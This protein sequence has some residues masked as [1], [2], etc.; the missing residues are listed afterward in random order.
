M[1][2]ADCAEYGHFV[3]GE[4]A[5]GMAF[6]IQTFTAKITLAVSGAISM[7]LL[8]AVG[9]AEGEGAVQTQET[10]AWLWR[11][12]TVIPVI[13]G[14]ASFLILLLFYRL[15]D[16]DVSVMMKANSGEITREEALS[17]LSPKAL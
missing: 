17:Q 13:A 4:R 5:Q 12:Y 15:R 14:L 9:F 2:T 7:F 11:M 10:V 6:S 1:F 8:G 16:R 3:T